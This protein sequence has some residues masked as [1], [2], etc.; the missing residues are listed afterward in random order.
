MKQVEA[1]LVDAA[2][3]AAR[4][5]EQSVAEIPLDEIARVAG[6]SRS[7]LL[8]R[9]GGSRATL[10]E[11]VRDAGVDPGGRVP[12]RERAVAAAARLIADRG[13]GSVTLA[14]VA[15]EAGCSLPA[16]HVAFDGRDSLLAAVFDRHSPLP[17]LIAVAQD[18]P[19]EL[20][21]LVLRVYRTLITVLQREP[22]VFPAL[23]SDL[24]SRPTGPAAELMRGNAP[25]VAEALAALFGPHLDSG[26]LRRLPFPILLQLL[27]GPM[28][29]HVVL[30]P[31]L[32][33][34]LP[35]PPIDDAAELFAA[36]FLR[37]AG[38]PP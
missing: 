14:S 26:A 16:V 7:T 18:P 23:L 10:D 20:E 24:F 29:L 9:L 34:A 17:E 38:T 21:Q 5:R 35:M 1:A 31:G 37:A 13:L 11:A 36:A 32:E 30:R 8:R 33:A 22:R 19:A 15:D 3:A 12:V 28:L 25:K 2:I 4:E 6:I 27:I